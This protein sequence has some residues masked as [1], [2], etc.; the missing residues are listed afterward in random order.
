MSYER[1]IGR[2]YRARAAELRA[3]AEMDRNNETRNALQ[4]VAVDY[5]RMAQTM[6]AIA[7]TNESLRRA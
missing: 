5:E 4:K 3:I 2:S 6:D 7:L 1:D